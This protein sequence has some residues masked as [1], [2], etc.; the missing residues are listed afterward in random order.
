[1]GLKSCGTMT[2]DTIILCGACIPSW[3]IDAV[4][5][6][7]SR[8]Q[9]T[10][11]AIVRV[12]SLRER[13][14]VRSAES[15]D[16][17]SFMRIADIHA[18]DTRRCAHNSIDLV[19]R[20]KV[21]VAQHRSLPAV[22]AVPFEQF[23][24]SERPPP[25]IPTKL[26]HAGQT[27]LTIW[28]RTSRY[29]SATSSVYAGIDA[30]CPH[31]NDVF[32]VSASNVSLLAQGRWLQRNRYPHLPLTSHTPVAR[33]TAVLEDRCTI[34]CFRPLRVSSYELE[35]RRSQFALTKLNG[36]QHCLHCG[37]Y[38]TAFF[39]KFDRNEVRGLLEYSTRQSFGN[40]RRLRGQTNVAVISR[41]SHNLRPD[42][43]TFAK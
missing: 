23:L 12:A 14:D 41:C 11:P 17:S 1:M 32:V 5:A 16:D 4:R 40:S 33:R 26:L 13:L 38:T 24:G 30:C 3:S 21:D 19:D 10:R 25:P 42:F 8:Q 39:S 2:T 36:E 27:L 37:L 6:S 20:V 34:I 9:S 43:K 35:P 28:R 31:R 7:G 29:L 22:Y 18:S 15:R